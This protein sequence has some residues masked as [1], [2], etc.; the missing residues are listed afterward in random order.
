[1][2]FVVAGV[3]EMENE[4]DR[5]AIKKAKVLYNSCMNE[6]KALCTLSNNNGVLSLE[7]GKKTKIQFVFLE[8]FVVLQGSQVTFK[9][10]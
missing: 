3:L 2:C 6:S 4:Q 10:F 9:T 1:M 5:N 8:L 7:G